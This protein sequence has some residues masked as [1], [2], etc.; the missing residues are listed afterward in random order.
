MEKGK[1]RYGIVTSQKKRIG[2][3][4]FKCRLRGTVASYFSDP[5]GKFD[6]HMIVASPLSNCVGRGC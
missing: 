1:I 5:D 4:V 2:G 3:N 6:T